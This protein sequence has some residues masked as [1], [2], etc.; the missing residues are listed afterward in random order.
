M[1]TACHCGLCPADQSGDDWSGTDAQ[2][3]PWVCLTGQQ[4]SPVNLP[5][6]ATAVSLLDATHRSIFQLGSMVS[7]GS[8]I[9]VRNSGHSVEVAWNDPNFAPKISIV[10]QGK[11]APT[12]ESFVSYR[13]QE[14]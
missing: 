4:Q 11:V 14:C 9:R 7:N 3:D 1:L 5:T 13:V 2:G 10:V 12:V 6:A 8:N